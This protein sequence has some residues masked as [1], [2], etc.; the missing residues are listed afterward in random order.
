MTEDTKVGN[1]LLKKGE[2]FLIDMLHLHRNIKE[3][4]KPEI[5]I[6]ER[7]DPQSEWYLR[8]DGT[9]RHPMAFSPFLGGKRICL[10]KTFAETV[11]KIVGPSILGHFD[12]EFVDKKYLK[13]QVPNS[14]VMKEE[15]IVMI[16]IKE[17]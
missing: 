8:P 15:P 6:P 13:E 4:K 10:G 2:P 9:K 14:L 16:K 3:W 11:S 5:Y 7:F 1:L 17:I 12:F